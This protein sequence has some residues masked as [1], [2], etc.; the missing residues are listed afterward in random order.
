VQKEIEKYINNDILFCL[1]NS[2]ELAEFTI[3]SDDNVSSKV[4]IKDDK[5]LLK[6]NYPL[7][8]TKGNKTYVLKDFSGESKV[9][10]GIVYNVAKQIIDEQIKNKEGI[11]I[12][13]L[14]ELGWK[15][16]VY[17]KTLDYKEDMIY[18]ITDENSKVSEGILTFNFVN[19]YE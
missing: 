13:C 10:L 15:N 2:P 8:I 12:G 11:C 5:V 19:K 9:R 14:Y 18:T 7:S 3:Q 1:D 6:V 17:I 16:D 4:E